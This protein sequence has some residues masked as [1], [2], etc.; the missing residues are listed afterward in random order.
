[1]LEQKA[2]IIALEAA[3]RKKKKVCRRGVR[4]LTKLPMTDT[5]V[6]SEHLKWHICL[7]EDDEQ[8]AHEE[9]DKA[10]HAWFC[11]TKPKKIHISGSLIQQKVLNYAC[12]LCIKENLRQVQGGSNDLRSAMRWPRRYCMESPLLKIVAVRHC[13]ASNTAYIIKK[14]AA[15]YVY[16]ADET[17]SSM[18]FYQQ[19]RLTSK[20]NSATEASWAERESPCCSVQI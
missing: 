6:K 15:S 7:T 12:T 11:K 1:M 20:A 17:G 5:E 3:G 2:E 9:L 18:K 19:R 8:P 16:N 10:V 4:C 13:R 14:Y